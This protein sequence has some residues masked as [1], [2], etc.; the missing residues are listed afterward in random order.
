MGWAVKKPGNWPNAKDV[1]SKYGIPHRSIG[2]DHICGGDG[3]QNPRPPRGSFIIR[4]VAEMG[5]PLVHHKLHDS[6][7]SVFCLRPFHA[8]VESTSPLLRGLTGKHGKALSGSAMRPPLV[9]T[10]CPIVRSELR[11]HSDPPRCR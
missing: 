11:R 3:R 2:D 8:L 4:G 1:R 6:T 9:L 7:L 10:A 5:R